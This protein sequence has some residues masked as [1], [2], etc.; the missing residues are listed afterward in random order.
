[1]S[2]KFFIVARH[3]NDSSEELSTGQAENLVGGIRSFLR[4]KG[5][6]SLPSVAV[7]A[8]T[9]RRADPVVNALS[10]A[11]TRVFVIRDGVYTHDSTHRFKQVMQFLVGQFEFDVV[12][13]IAHLPTMLE[14][15]S[16]GAELCGYGG[17]INLLSGD[18][19]R[20]NVLDCRTGENFLLE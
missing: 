16:F 4:E 17:A 3:P 7:F 13:V 20:A 6:D 19:A 11:F 1:M 9:A 2:M 5:I 8:S 18:Y 10:L 14:M 12:I 15:L